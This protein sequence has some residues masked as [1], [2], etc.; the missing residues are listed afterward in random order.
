MRGLRVASPRSVPTD[1]VPSFIVVPGIG[2]ETVVD[3]AA[4]VESDYSPSPGVC[5]ESLALSEV[6]TPRTLTRQADC[7][8]VQPLAEGSRLPLAPYRSI[9][10]WVGIDAEGNVATDSAG[11]VMLQGSPWSVYVAP[12]VGFVAGF[13]VYAAS[14]ATVALPLEIGGVTAGMVDVTLETRLGEGDWI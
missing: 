11:E 1:T 5:V 8:V 2:A 9:L 6:S 10:Y 12:P 13:R 7:D 3:A 4:L 14:D